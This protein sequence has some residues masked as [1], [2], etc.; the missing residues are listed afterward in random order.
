MENKKFILACPKCN[1]LREYKSYDAYFNAVKKET[2]CRR[3]ST[4]H[5]AKRKSDCSILLNESNESYYWMGFILADGHITNNNRLVVGLSIKDKEH[6]ARL[7]VYLKSDI[8]EYKNKCTLNIM[9]TE[10]LSQ[11]RTRFNIN[12]NKTY[13]PPNLDVFNISE[14][15]LLSLFSGFIDGDGS[16]RNLYNR[17][18]FNLQIKCHSSWLSILQLFA[19]K[20]LLGYQAKINKQG[21]AYLVCGDSQILKNLKEKVLPL[22]LPLLKRKWDIIT[23]TFVSRV[24]IS[25]NR[26]LE[27]QKYLKMGYLQKEIYPIIK[28]SKGGLSLLISKNNLK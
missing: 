28:M 14:D 13:N 25:D 24:E 1:N 3:C 18:D 16:I 5:S 7:A 19:D 9:D 21:Y 20:F 27:V 11:I 22:N 4:Q 26:I 23:N 8:I 17:P 10:S 6:L 15:K 12:H 2:V